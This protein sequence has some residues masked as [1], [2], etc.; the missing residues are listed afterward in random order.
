MERILDGLAHYVLVTFY[1]SIVV[2]IFAFMFKYPVSIP[3]FVLPPLLIWAVE[4]LKAKERR[5]SEKEN[6][7]K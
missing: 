4:R 3:F 2:L 7:S 6:Y 1:A 5:D